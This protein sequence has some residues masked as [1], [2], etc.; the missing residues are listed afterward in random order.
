MIL[1]FDPGVTTGVALLK[2]DGTILDT[3]TVQSVEEMESY[4]YA[5]K[6]DRKAT[7]PLEDIVCVAE[8]GPQQSGNYRPHIQEIEEVIKKYF[9]DVH[10]VPPG[11][12]KGHPVATS[13][14]V[15]K[16]QHEKDAV[17]LARWYRKT[18]MNVT[19]TPN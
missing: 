11:Q 6:N 1:S 14:D 16:T 19:P 12:W 10:W 8:Q 7:D 5:V 17:G 2:D 3:T 18:R 9:Y 13:S 15:K 4:C